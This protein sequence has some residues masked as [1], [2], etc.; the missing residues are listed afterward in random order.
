MQTEIGWL[1]TGTI[2]ANMSLYTVQIRVHVNK[3]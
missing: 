3:V 2:G 1:T